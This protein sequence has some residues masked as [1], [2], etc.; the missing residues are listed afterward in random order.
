ML[1][2]NEKDHFLAKIE[3]EEQ[4]YNDFIKLYSYFSIKDPK[5]SY[6]AKV[7]SGASDG[8]IRFVKKN[9]SFL[10]GLLNKIVK[11]LDKEEIEYKVNYSL[12]DDTVSKEEIFEFID[13]ISLPFKP[14]EFQKEGVYEAVRNRQKV[15]ISATGSGK[16]CILY[17]TIRYLLT[18]NEQILLVVPDVGLTL[19]MYNDFKEYAKNDKEHLK[20]FDSI[21]HRIFAGQDK[22]SNHK[23]I[24]STWQ[25]IYDLD[26]SHNL[27]NKTTVVL[28]DECHLCSS[29]SYHDIFT[30]AKNVKK[31]IGV[32]GTLPTDLIDQLKLEGIFATSKRIISGRGLIELGL[33]TESVVQPIILKYDEYIINKVYKAKDW[34]Y[35]QKTIIE[36]ESRLEFL[37]NFI[38]KLANKQKGNVIVLFKNVEYGDKLYETI[39]ESHENTFLIKGSINSKRREEIRSNLDNMNNA[40]LIGT[41]KIVSTGLNIKSLRYM[42]NTQNGKSEIKSIQSIGRLMRLFDGKD[43]STLFDIVDDLNYK[44]RPSKNYPKG[45]IKECY[46]WKWYQERLESYSKYDFIVKN[47]VKFSLD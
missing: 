47:S 33:A 44:T 18:K 12:V 25:S 29:S 10:K 22:D 34:R 21:Y 45:N 7:R 26:K 8:K 3:Y 2:I 42:V 31:R 9:G 37:V 23:V 28:S 5:L 27:F 17:L 32:T 20:D 35:E 4:D 16:S 6:T 43:S 14:Y 36:S 13:S 19:Q 15:I 30:K 39:K 46:V 11:F 24:I 38:T 40:V 1:I 41:D